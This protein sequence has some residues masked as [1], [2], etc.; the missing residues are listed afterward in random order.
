MTPEDLSRI[1][2]TSLNEAALTNLSSFAGMVTRWNPR[3]NLISP[4]TLPEIWTRHIADSAQLFRYLPERADSLVDIGSGGGFPAIVLAIL[5]AASGRRMKIDL[6]ES[7]RRKAAFLSTALRGLGLSATVHPRRA[8]EVAPLAAAVVTARALAP[9]ERLVPL[10][11]RHLDRD[12]V[13]IF[14]KGRNHLQELAA[15]SERFRVRDI[16]P[17]LTDAESAIIMIERSDHA[18]VG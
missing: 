2:G 6:I 15:G 1:A 3:I 14:P 17:S 11:L 5:L 9:L 13:G 4:G 10:A 7:D 16:V 12:G 8:D 18:A